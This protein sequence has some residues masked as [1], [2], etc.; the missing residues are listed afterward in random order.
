MARV[1]ETTRG[2]ERC[3]RSVHHRCGKG[4]DPMIAVPA[5]CPPP[6]RRSQTF[7]SIGTL[8]TL[9]P[10]NSV[11]GSGPSTS[12]GVNIGPF[13]P[14]AQQALSDLFG[15]DTLFAG[16]AESVLKLGIEG[17]DEPKEDLPAT[18]F[19][20]SQVFYLVPLSRL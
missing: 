20:I 15:R 8:Y 5:Y 17:L 6:Q 7:S 4:D 12:T 18:S 1:R 11:I 16:F 10:T 3:I 14:S 2:K 9:I 19:S 13:L